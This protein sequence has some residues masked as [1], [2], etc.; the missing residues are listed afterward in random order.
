V[1]VPEIIHPYRL[2]NP[3]QTTKRLA[4]VAMCTHL[5]PQASPLLLC[6]LTLMMDLHDMIMHATT[7]N[8]AQES[9]FL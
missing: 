1:T 4:R 5:S 7:N 9:E 8:Q 2:N 3:P 6:L